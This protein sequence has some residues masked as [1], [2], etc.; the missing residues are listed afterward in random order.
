MSMYELCNYAD[1]LRKADE[2]F[3]P[4][5]AEII[6]NGALAPFGANQRKE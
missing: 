6:A 2:L 4:S 5:Y 3:A 1:L